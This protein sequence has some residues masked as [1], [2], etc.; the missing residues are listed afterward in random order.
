M[1]SI[2]PISLVAGAFWASWF[3]VAAHATPITY[4]LENATSTNFGLMDTYTGTFTF[5]PTKAS[6]ISLSITITGTGA[7][8]GTYTAPLNNEVTADRIAFINANLIDQRITFADPLGSTSDNIAS[9]FGFLGFTDEVTGEA[10]PQISS[11]PEPASL[12]IF[13]AS[14]AMLGV[15]RR[16]RKTS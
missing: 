3:A 13:G 9:T 12:A 1:L 2:R 7:D 5:D 16:K 14:L 10:V 6:L 4:T 15:M 8:N 11:V